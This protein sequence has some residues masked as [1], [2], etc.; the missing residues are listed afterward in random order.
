MAGRRMSPHSGPG[1]EWYL[2]GRPG[3]TPGLAGVYEAFPSP[4]NDGS[5]RRSDAEKSRAAATP[6]IAATRS[7]NSELERLQHG[8]RA[9]AD[10]EL[11][12]DVRHVILDRA[13]GDAE[14]VR[15]LLV[16]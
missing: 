13:L 2:S 14:R 6:P 1:A 9:V 11:G 7:D 12:E 15:D 4:E 5:D 16:A 10:A 3:A 8:A